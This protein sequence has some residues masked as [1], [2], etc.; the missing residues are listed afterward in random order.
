MRALILASLLSPPHHQYECFS[1]M[2]M[3]ELSDLPEVV[4]VRRLL[5]EIDG[6]HGVLGREPRGIDRHHCGP[7]IQSR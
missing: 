6:S 5:R 3:R 1:Y 4:L 2:F 7:H